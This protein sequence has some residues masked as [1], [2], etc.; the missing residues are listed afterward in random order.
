MANTK[1]SNPLLLAAVLGLI[2]GLYGVFEALV[3][4]T[5]PTGLGSYV[6]WGLGVAL[7]LLFLGLS[8][9]GLLINCLVYILG[10]KEMDR[11]AGIVT[12][13][14]LLTEV[15]A[16]I[17]IAL[18]LGHWER[19]YRFIVS[20]SPTSPMFWMLIF[21]TAVL[22]VYAVKALA[23][24][25]GNQSLARL[26]SLVSIPV[27]LCFYA[28]NGYFF[29]IITSHP[30]WSGA[31]TTVWFVLAALLSGGGLT[32]ALAWFV[33][34]EAEVTVSLGRTVAVLLGCFLLFEWLYFSAG[35]RGGRPD[36]AMA[37]TAMLTGQAAWSFWLVHIGLGL[38]LPLAL[39]L[40]GRNSPAAVAWAG[41]LI[42]AGFLAYRYTFVVPAQSVPMLPG[43]DKA[44]QD[45]R[46]TLAY[47]PTLGEWLVTLWVFSLALA[48][49][50]LGPRLF[51]RLFSR[52]AW[53]QPLAR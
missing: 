39:L 41:L 18:D 37:L 38:L 42:V 23:I 14:T 22:V 45:P 25:V 31:F 4:R 34:D 35:F 52:P 20:P 10:K 3:F 15:C 28:T 53:L 2:A 47:V 9:G 48:G 11:I 44:W 6:P 50:V 27:S 51:P 32:A 30:A 24:I 5:E 19:M 21:F 26:C 46:L 1:R 13:A 36:L 43:L 17:A 49:F 7:Y 33:Q 16:G 40:V 12:Y 29:S 8:A